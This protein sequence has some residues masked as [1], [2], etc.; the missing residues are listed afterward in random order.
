[1]IVADANLIAH[2]H[3]P[4]P[5]ESVAE[6]IL[7]KDPDWC[8]PPLWQSEFRN[9]LFAYIRTQGMSLSLAEAQWRDALSLIGPHE[10]DVDA[11]RVLGKS[12]STQLSA[13]DA[14]YVVL[15]ESLSLPL[16]TSDRQILAACP[17]LAL[18]LEDFIA[19]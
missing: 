6:A 13:Y 17:Q 9:I 4:G 16:V 19:A 14:E 8:A 3:L 15:A 5:K 10:F 1:M 12:T 11:S 2:L 7:A 18:S